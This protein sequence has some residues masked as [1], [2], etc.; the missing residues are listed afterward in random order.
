MKSWAVIAAGASGLAALVLWWALHGAD[1]R[2]FTAADASPVQAALPVCRASPYAAIE[3]TSEGD[4]TL[5][6]VSGEQ[7]VDAR[8]VEISVRSSSGSAI[9][10]TAIT[11][12]DP[13]SKRRLEAGFEVRF[14]QMV[15]RHPLPEGVSDARDDAWRRMLEHSAFERVCSAPDPSLQRLLDQGA[16]LHWWSGTP[17][18]PDNY[19]VFVAASGS[20]AGQ[21]IEYLGANHRRLAP[22]QFSDEL[23]LVDQRGPLRLLRSGHGAVVVDAQRQ[24]YAWVYIYPGGR[25]LRLPSVV[26]GTFEGDSIVLQID[27]PATGA[28]NQRVEIDLRTGNVRELH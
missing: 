22:S 20:E 21:W 4:E 7:N 26:A 17:R 8:G 5:W 11:L 15:T 27:Q 24:A 3:R 16:A 6:Q 12:F 19:A 28:A 9:S 2:Q 25:K 10:S 18:M 23:Q 1:D 13:R 14:D